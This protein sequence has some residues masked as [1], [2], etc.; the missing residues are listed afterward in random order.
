MAAPAAGRLLCRGGRRSGRH[1]GARRSGV[2]APQRDQARRLAGAWARPRRSRQAG[3]ARHPD[4]G[5]GRGRAAH[6]P[7]DLRAGRIRRRGGRR[8]GAAH[9]VARLRRAAAEAAV[10]ARAAHQRLQPRGARRTCATRRGPLGGAA[11]ARTGRGRRNQPAR[12]AGRRSGRAG[13]DRGVRL[14][15]A[16]AVVLGALLHRAPLS[17]EQG[18][19]RVP[20]PRASRRLGADQR[21][22]R[23]LPH[24]QR[25]AGAVG[26]SAM[27]AGRRPG[28]APCRGG[29][30]AAVALLARLRPRR[31][32]LR[33]GAQPRRERG[34]GA[35]RV[36]RPRSGGRAGERIC[37]KAPGNGVDR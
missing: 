8:L 26:W 23:G 34:L 30:P 13:R 37:A 29:E 16:A 12:H 35:R 1:R 28:A 22:R 19:L 11:G 14:R 10:R 27:P 18:H 2:L 17:A 21:R 31:R 5:D 4:L 25:H 6:R 32:R 15:A 9:P 3:G 7:P 24:P 33:R 20:L 36:R